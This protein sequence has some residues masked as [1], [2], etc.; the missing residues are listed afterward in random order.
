MSK[1]KSQAEMPVKEVIVL[2]PGSGIG[3]QDVSTL[4]QYFTSRFSVSPIISDPGSNR[5]TDG[6]D[7]KLSVMSPIGVVEDTHKTSGCDQ[8]VTMKIVSYGSS[9]QVRTFDQILQSMRNCLEPRRTF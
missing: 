2:K 3:K 4:M 9:D 6:Y 8:M 1:K 5:K 7:R